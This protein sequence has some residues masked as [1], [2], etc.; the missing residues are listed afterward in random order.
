MFALRGHR[1]TLA[2]VD[3]ATARRAYDRLTTQAA[4]FERAGLMPVGAGE[5]IA[6]NLTAA[7]SI[8]SAVAEADYVTEAVPEDPEIKKATLTRISSALPDASIVGTNTSAIPIARLSA[9]VSAPERFLGVHWMNPAPFIPGVELIPGPRT[10][11]ETI[12][13][14][15]RL[16]GSLGKV[17]AR[18]TDSPGFVANRLQFALFKEAS[19]IVEEGIAT[20]AEI[21]AIVSSTFGFRLALFGPFAIG[22]MAGLD[23]YASSY[24]TLEDAFGERFACPK[25]VREAVEDNNLGV[26]AGGGLRGV[27]QSQVH[28]LLGY[29]DAAYVRLSALRSELGAAPGL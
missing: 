27:D 7:E 5:M 1:V 9:W 10:S 21:D 17:T 11:P 12:D 2:D 3:G 8:E 18:V 22:D 4:E 29:R 20:P 16:I 15:E 28:A 24:R 26:K 13:H 6:A 23:V 19:R 25:A 14:A